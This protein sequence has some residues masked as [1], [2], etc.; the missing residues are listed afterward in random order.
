M[1]SGQF[2]LQAVLIFTAI[3]LLNVYF[4]KTTPYLSKKENGQIKPSRIIS[5]FCVVSCFLFFALCLWII[6]SGDDLIIGFI[7]AS[8]ALFGAIVMLPSL[9]NSH[10]IYWD[11]TGITG[12]TG[13]SF[14][15]FP[16]RQITLKWDDIVKLDEAW[17]NYQY[18]EDNIG[19]RIFWG[20]WYS[21][22]RELADKVRSYLN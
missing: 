15:S 2:I 10:D 18:I 4:S 19:R 13:K 5:V 9:S 20:Y 22:E 14:P 7:G 16:T 11:E 3:Y 8:A 21:G 6:F 1:G 12:P 17:S